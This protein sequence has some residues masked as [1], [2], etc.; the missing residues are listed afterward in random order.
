MYINFVAGYVG[1]FTMEIL[2]VGSFCK[3]F[4]DVNKNIEAVADP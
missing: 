3:M 2:D 4:F 1:H